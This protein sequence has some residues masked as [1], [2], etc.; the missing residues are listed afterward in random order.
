MNVLRFRPMEERD[1]GEIAEL[2][3]VSMNTWDVV[4]GFPAGR[5]AE[6]SA[7]TDLFYAVYEGLDP[8]SCMVGES[9]E[10]GRLAASCYY[11][12]RDTHVSLGIMNVHP[13]YFGKGIAR[14]LLRL[15]TDFAD[16]R[17]KP[18]R[19]VSSVMNLDSFSLYT[20]AGFVPRLALPGR[21]GGGA[22]EGHLLGHRRKWTR[23][24][25]DGGRYRG[26]GGGRARRS[27]GSAGVKDYR[28]LRR[29]RRRLLGHVR[30]REDGGGLDGYLAS[31]GHP[32]FIEIGPG[33]AR[34]EQQ[35]A[36]LLVRRAQPLSAAERPWSWSLS[37]ATELVRLLYRL[38]GRNCEVHAAQVRGGA[39]PFRG[40]SF[41]TF[42]PETG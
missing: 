6:G 38:G 8:G 17:N 16:L 42:M 20:R 36:A 1:R 35:A 9:V 5:F 12:E 15:I 18:L 26:H 7:Q 34:D 31:I 33:V 25:R 28:A 27:A 19:L 14:E 11:R 40:V 22:A 32:L 41:P 3:A 10:T 13:N 21:A 4:H 23:P 30:H 37:S 2:V 24:R 39:E 29:E